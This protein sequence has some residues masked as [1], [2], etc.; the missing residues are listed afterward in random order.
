MCSRSYVRWVASQ[1]PLHR[2]EFTELDLWE[3]GEGR[4]VR[5]LFSGI[6]LG[7]AASK[8]C[9][10][11]PSAPSRHCATPKL[12]IKELSSSLASDKKLSCC[13]LLEG[14]ASAVWP[15]SCYLRGTA[16]YVHAAEDASGV[17]DAPAGRA[18]GGF[19]R[20]LGCRV[21]HVRT[22]LSSVLLF[23]LFVVSLSRVLRVCARGD[24]GYTFW[25]VCDPGAA[26]LGRSQVTQV[27]RSARS[28]PLASTS[29][30]VVNRRDA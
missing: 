29:I 25:G 26:A 24:T 9:L 8:L 5:L 19:A 15:H 20:A 27:Y 11:C 4:V 6:V 2:L 28:A 17:A 1:V 22:M 12:P 21:G 7:L 3:L 14:L 13:A 30:Q 16:S 18:C 23:A 10:E